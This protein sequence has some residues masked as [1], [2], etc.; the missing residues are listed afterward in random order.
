MKQ[1]CIHSGEVKSPGYY[2]LTNSG[3][4]IVVPYGTL[5]GFLIT[6]GLCFTMYGH[7]ALV[8]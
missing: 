5:S 2:F 3:I 4:L 8:P 1:T 6:P 7:K